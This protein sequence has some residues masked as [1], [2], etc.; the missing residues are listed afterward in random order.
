MCNIKPTT[1]LLISTTMNIFPICTHHGEP[2][3][4]ATSSK[5]QIAYNVLKPHNVKIVF[6]IVLVV[7]ALFLLRGLLYEH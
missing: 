6:S 7:F 2:N 3:C 4:M 5:A 1:E